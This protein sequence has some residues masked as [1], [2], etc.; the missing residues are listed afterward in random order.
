MED[1]REHE[2]G[3]RRE[4]FTEY[5][6]TH[7]IGFGAGER[8]AAFAGHMKIETVRNRSPLHSLWNEMEGTHSEEERGV[9]ERAPARTLSSTPTRTGLKS[10]AHNRDR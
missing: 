9:I 5:D 6:K 2:K 4:L 1:R 7:V 3:E 8:S 10:F